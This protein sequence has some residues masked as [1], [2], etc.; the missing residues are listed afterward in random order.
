MYVYS[1]KCVRMCVC[2]YV[3]RLGQRVN[4]TAVVGVGWGKCSS[5]RLQFLEFSQIANAISWHKIV[6]RIHL[7]RRTLARAVQPFSW[8]LRQVILSDLTAAFATNRVYLADI[9]ILGRLLLHMYNCGH[10]NSSYLT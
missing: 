6:A 10:K 4:V 9:H 5:C 1:Q 7:R 2:M 3:V 8:A